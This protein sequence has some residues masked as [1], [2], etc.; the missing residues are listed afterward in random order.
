VYSVNSSHIDFYVLALLGI[1]GYLLR[2][3]GY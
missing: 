1:A 2:E 3:M